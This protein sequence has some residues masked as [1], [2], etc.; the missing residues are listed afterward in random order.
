MS[1]ITDQ[2]DQKNRRKQ[3]AVGTPRHGGPTF[4]TDTASLS[5]V[6]ISIGGCDGYDER[7]GRDTPRDDATVDG[8][9]DESLVETL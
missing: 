2:H 4:Q 9:A 6:D 8:D 3:Q 1:E 7:Q 5:D